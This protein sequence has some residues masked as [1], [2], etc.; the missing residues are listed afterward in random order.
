MNRTE[1]QFDIFIIGSG[2]SG[3]HAALEAVASG[4]KVALLDVGYT[5]NRFAPLVPRQSFSDI[6]KS[7]PHQRAYFLGDNPA[8]S[9]RSQSKGGVHLTPARQHMIRDMDTLFPL[10]AVSF[11]PLQSSGLG[12]LGISWG[13]NC[14]AL[15]KFEL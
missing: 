7:D 8:E 3:S 15:E 1:P 2:P 5:D 13:A 4:R 11:Q 14:F 6:R 12:G 10:E 9:L